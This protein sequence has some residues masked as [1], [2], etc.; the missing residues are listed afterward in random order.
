MLIHTYIPQDRWH[1]LGRGEAL[2]D[3]THG[4]AL[5][6]DISGFTPLT[7]LLRH[8]LGP[9]RGAEELTRQLDAV[10]ST[11]IAAVEKYGGS[12]IG[13]AG[14][15]IT[16]W[17]DERHGAAALR[18]L[19][20]AFALQEAM[21]IFSMIGL[22]NG[23]TTAL[24]LKVA[25]AT[26][27][28]R[29]FV[30]GD[31]AFYYLDALAGVTVTRTAIA[32]Q[33]AQKGEIVV[34][35][36]TVRVL[37]E[38][39][40][41]REWRTDHE[42]GW[43]FAVI[44][45]F[46]GEAPAF[47]VESIPPLNEA[48][49]QNWVHRLVYERERAGQSSFLNEFR[50]CT[51]L[52]VRFVGLDYDRPEAEAQLD[53]FIRQT[54]KIAARYEGVL[55]QVTIGDKG[56]YAYLNFG[57]LSA[58][59]DDARRAVK[60]ALK[61]SEA[62]QALGFLAPLQIGL[63][64]GIMLVGAYGGITR[65]TYGALGDDV[66]LAARLM[67]TAAPGEILL[68]EQVQKATAAHFTFISRPS[69]LLKGKAAP[70][71]AFVVSGERQY[72]PI[73]LHEPTYGLPMV[74]RHNELHRINDRLDST[75][76][77]RAQLIGIVA[78]AGLGKSRLVAEVIRLA[79][80]TGFVSY[81]GACQSDGVN[82]PYLAWKP[83]W[84]TFFD[85]D[86]SAPLPQ[87]IRSLAGKIEKQAPQ[88]LEALPLLG[89]L[90]NLT[91]P[92][93]GFTQTLEPKYRQSALYALLADCLRTAA[94]AEPLLIVI[95]DLH[96]I[97]ALSHELLEELA[98]ALTDSS[99]CFL[100]AY[101]PPQLQRLQAP[102]LEALPSFTRIELQ[103]LNSSECE[104]LI[105]AKLGQSYPAWE[106]VAPPSLVETLIAR[107]Q[108]NP[109]YLEELL[110]FLR[111]RNLDPRESTALAE[112][113]LP[114]TLH[115]LILSRIDQLTEREKAVLRVAAIIGRLFRVNWLLGYYPGLGEWEQVKADLDELHKVDITP[116]N[117]PEPE[118]SYLFKHIVTHEVTYES[119]P[120]A[121][122]ARLH[123]QLGHYL[124]EQIAGG[125]QEEPFLLDTLVHH[126]SRSEN[127][128][129]ERE[130][131]HK[132]GQAALAVSAFIAGA[133]YFDRLL[134]LTPS[135]DPDYCLLTL[136]LAELYL[137]LGDYAAVH[138]AIQKTQAVATT[139]A[140]QA[141]ALAILGEMA[142]QSGD[143]AGAQ[144][145]LAEAVPLARAAN[146][147]TTLCGAL[148]ALGDAYWR[149][150]KQDEAQAALSESLALAHTLGD[151][152]RELFALNRLGVLAALQQKMDEAERM[153]QEVHIRA[154]S[155]GNRERA[156]SALNNLGVVAAERQDYGAARDYYQQALTLAHEVGE[157]SAMAL[158]LLNLAAS[159]IGLGQL[160]PAR[161]ELR[162]GLAL[163]LRIGALPRAV[164]AVIYF[165]HLAQVEG[166]I[167]QA[168]ALFGLARAHPAWSSDLRRWQ[169]ATLA[170]WS[171]D[172]AVVET[173]LAKGKMLNW[174][175]TI[176]TLL[177]T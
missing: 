75:R 91:I 95:E 89:A 59:E 11:L 42:T 145:I 68:S 90:L 137:R 30:V 135:T 14:D 103:E 150:G 148:Y 36:T 66:N 60:A 76:Q 124:E 86:P 48:A 64:Q 166:Q 67:Q 38:V 81:G 46:T 154:L 33:L 119:L 157:Q 28:A 161:V 108:G 31:P 143:Y 21:P 170:K 53:A 1:A 151:I 125:W 61:L 111:D 101:R 55:L 141:A 93:N 26:G 131:L 35:E 2:P 87:Q 147:Q 128:A 54:Q 102:R 37:D 78:E 49:L 18:A 62:A 174:D 43:P 162:Q 24:T 136:Q 84:G 45:Q 142:S 94:R 134:A 25:I 126:Y 144:T 72:R 65:R 115:T 168:L 80:R 73:H 56:S 88:R 173:G 158:C 167:E 140:E 23:T 121:T 70:L 6:A 105:R 114:D 171:L 34:D 104:Q 19:A 41:I 40:T 123:E 175:A 77:G 160:A 92:D 13:F 85:V 52:F 132:A 113:D 4:S 12:V 129:K 109:F 69:L 83:I 17:F 82:T 20:C 22:P 159:D 164:L 130:Y 152:N 127:R 79:Y 97:D 39:L 100:L 138:K 63:T 133:E 74:G 51:A 110:N 15:A 146:E 5:F 107:T 98:R 163:A 50:P 8:S 16:C 122:R 3:R 99:V 9:R 155:V 44:A 7:E 149:L 156:M 165:A 176:Q 106:G 29:R 177:Q 117:T 47:R 10:Y 32:E 169:E 118:L 172:P 57:A 153:V 27:S 58:H 120:F 96:W 71:T 112:I 139:A 116:L